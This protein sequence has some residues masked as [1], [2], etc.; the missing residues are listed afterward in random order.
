[1]AILLEDLIIRQ[2]GQIQQEGHHQVIIDPIVDRQHL[3]EVRVLQDHLLVV[4]VYSMLSIA[5]LI[6]SPAYIGTTPL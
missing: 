1:M 2:G 3:Q 6:V 5:Q 4:E